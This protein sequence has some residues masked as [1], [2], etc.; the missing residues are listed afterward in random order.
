MPSAKAFWQRNGN[1]RELGAVL[2][3]STLT[4]TEGMTFDNKSLKWLPDSV[5]EVADHSDERCLP[6]IRSTVWSVDRTSPF[7]AGHLPKKPVPQ[8]CAVSALKGKNSCGPL[9]NQTW[10]TEWKTAILAKVQL[11]EYKTKLWKLLLRPAV[12]CMPSLA[13]QWPARI[14]H[15]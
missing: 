7:R 10:R 1:R 3:W 8:S 14:F 6:L 15:V 13:V 11:Y 9:N 2:L 4:A 12:Q 5:Q